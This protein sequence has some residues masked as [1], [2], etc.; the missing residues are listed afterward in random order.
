MRALL[1]GP[2]TVGGEGAYMNLLRSHPPGDVQY[3]TVGG[4]HVGG[5]G[6]GCDVPVE[7][8]LNRIVRRATIPDM[9]FRALRLRE[10]FDLTHVHA[11]PVRLARLRGTPLVMSEG[12]SSAVYL[13]DYLGWDEHRLARGFRASRRIYRALG[14]R[15]RLLAMERVARVYV[16][17]DGRAASTCAGA[18]TRAS[19]TS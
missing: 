17:S 13:G 15:D 11:H 6:A 2:D 8:V 4:F 9:G 18:P 3:S 19:S 14:I 5:P 12:S 7:V 16:F 10:H 1:I